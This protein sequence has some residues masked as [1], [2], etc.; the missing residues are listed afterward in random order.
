METELLVVGGGPAGYTAAIRGA[1]RGL[2]VALV[3]DGLI[4]GTCLNHG[5]IPS[6]ALLSG[7]G[8]VHEMETASEMGIYV[9][10]YVDL[11]EMVAWKDGVVDRLTDGV[12]ALCRQNGVELVDGFA[13]FV[14]E[15]TVAVDDGREIEFENAVLA[16]GSRPITLPGFGFDADPIWDSRRALAAE[17]APPRLLVVG[18]GYIGM[19]LSTI[20]ARLG[21]DVTVVEMLEEPLPQYESDLTDP[22]LESVAELGVDINFGEAATNWHEDGRDVVVTTET[23]DGEESTYSVDEVLV[24]VGR[25]PVTAGLNLGAAAVE[26]DDRGFVE[27]DEHGRTTAENVFAVGDVAG[28]PM[29][30]H[31]GMHEGIVAAETVAGE[32]PPEARAVPAVVFTAPEIATVGLNPDEARAEGIDPLV[33]EFPFSASGRAMTTREA[34]GFVRLVAA[35]DGR[36]VGG[37]IVG[38]EAS[39]LIAEI[40]LAVQEGVTLEAVAETIHTHPTLSEATMEAAEHAL[41]RAIHTANR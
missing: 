19:E 29:L 24:A 31:A 6:K 36:V 10:P 3:E 41:G 12:A 33:G 2:D 5:C 4:G 17:R 1:Q 32:D 34:T 28:E 26:T 39:E 14:D 8:T 40:G 16:T 13:R 38:P 22:V 35:G 27:T 21:S 11:G 15:R 25:E 7:T 23:E 20:F 30:A 37:Q 18:A 9:E